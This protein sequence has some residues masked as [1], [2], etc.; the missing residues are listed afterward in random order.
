MGKVKHFRSHHKKAAQLAQE[1]GCICEAL[2]TERQALYHSSDYL[3][4]T[5]TPQHVLHHI[6][7]TLCSSPYFSMQQI[8][9]IHGAIQNHAV[10][11][12]GSG[13]SACNWCSKMGHHIEHCHSIGYCH[14]CLCCGHIGMDCMCPHD[15]CQDGGLCKVYPNHSNFK[16]SHCAAENEQYYFDNI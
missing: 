3:A 5:N 9:K 1:M 6:G 15:M 11:A 16:N 12:W 4:A 8:K 10:E 13:K 2:E 7:R 14:H